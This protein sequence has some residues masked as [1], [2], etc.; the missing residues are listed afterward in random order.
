MRN[1]THNSTANSC[2]KMFIRV[3]IRL[4]IFVVNH[5]MNAS[6]HHGYNG[7]AENRYTQTIIFYVAYRMTVWMCMVSEKH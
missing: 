7:S 2:K 5:Y 1:E 6:K 4:D 3:H